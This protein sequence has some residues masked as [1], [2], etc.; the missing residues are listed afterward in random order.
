MKKLLLLVIVAA[1]ACKQ[2]KGD[3]CQTNNDCPSPLVCNASTS[4]CVD[5]GTNP[6]DALAP[7]APRDA[8]G[9]DAHDAM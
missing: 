8:G 2:G 4:K 1:A 9:G 5:E 6:I 3:R 7:D